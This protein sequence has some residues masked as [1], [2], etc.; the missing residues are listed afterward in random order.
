MKSDALQKACLAATQR[1]PK[2]SGKK[3]VVT[4]QSENRFLLVFSLSEI[5]P[6]EKGLEQKVRVVT[7]A[8]GHII[9]MSSSR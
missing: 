7:D 8:D 9:K 4:E 5:L 6:G 2:L 3:P 1:N